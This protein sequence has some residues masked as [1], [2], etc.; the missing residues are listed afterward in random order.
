MANLF[1]N[2]RN[3]FKE[4]YNVWHLV[5]QQRYHETNLATAS[6]QVIC[7]ID[8]TYLETDFESLRKMAQI[9]FESAKAKKTVPGA[10]VVLR[11]YRWGDMGTQG[12]DNLYPRPLHFVSASPHQMRKVLAAK[13]VLDSLDWTSDTF[14]N[15]A[16]NIRK[17]R[18]NLLKNQAGYKTAAIL[19]LMTDGP[20][21]TNYF[22]I[23]DNAEHDPQIYLGI[24]LFVEGLISRSTYQRYL[25][26][27]GLD[28][29]D[30]EILMEPIRVP[31]GVRVGGIYIRK[32]ANKQ[33]HPLKPLSSWINYFND[34]FHLAVY[35]VHAGLLEVEHLLPIG[36]YFHNYENFTLADFATYL[37]R[38][39]EFL[40]KEIMVD[41]LETALQA[42]LT[43]SFTAR[44]DLQIPNPV[45]GDIHGLS[46]D[47]I[48]QLLLSW[49][50]K[51]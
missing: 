1:G 14:K 43:G 2:L 16:Y 11:Y 20:A 15:Q 8:K 6:A 22:M 30:F 41:E 3:R 17:G 28:E 9:P 12:S 24:K 38:A 23:G 49:V 13:L 7:D 40:P 34:F 33:E 26:T 45:V 29:E 36:R 44:S 37:E 50:A 21:N 32:L 42:K 19:K 46:E 51:K 39:K 5:D 35:L 18:F 4:R 27:L 47:E 31:A 48:G 25:Q 10:S